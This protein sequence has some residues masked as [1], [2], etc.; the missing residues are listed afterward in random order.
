MLT[1][2]PTC[3]SKEIEILINMGK[4]PMS[5]SI[6][7]TDETTELIIKSCKRCGMIFNATPIKGDFEDEY[8]FLSS[9]SSSIK[10]EAIKQ[11]NEIIKHYTD[12]SKGLPKIILEIASN[13]G[14]LLEE[15][16]KISP[17]TRMVGV[18]PSKLAYEIATKKGIEQFRGYFEKNNLDR[19]KDHC[20]DLPDI[21]IANNVITHVPDLREF[22][23]TIARLM[24]DKT[25][26]CIRFQSTER[27][28]RNYHYESFYHENYNFP[29]ILNIEQLAGNNGLEVYEGKEVEYHGGSVELWLRKKGG[30][31]SRN[32]KYYKAIRKESEDIKADME[33]VTNKFRKQTENSIKAFESFLKAA[34]A[35]KLS[36]GGYG[37]AQKAVTVLNSIDREIDPIKWIG[38][39]S[40]SKQGNIVPGTKIEVVSPEELLAKENDIII[41]FAWNLYEEIR[42]DLSRRGFDSKKILSIK[43]I[44]SM[45]PNRA[46]DA[47]VL[48]NELT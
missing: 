46:F 28:L 48:L 33:N 20:G 6:K 23:N 43:H 22:I 4:Q 47:A 39:I 21:I 41:V 36:V 30:K 37:A 17:N 35:Q 9:T 45:N 12:N 34:K 5:H 38:D 11:S 14:Y 8:H 40:K 24:G 1:V 15:L 31:A 16:K 13:D 3:E 26:A 2:C 7:Q 44:E 25:K 29:L 19:I 32:S 18:D 10:K 27:L 42:K